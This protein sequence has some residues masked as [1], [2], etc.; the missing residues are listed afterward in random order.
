VF[1]PGPER[2]KRAS[3]QYIFFL[4]EQYLSIIIFEDKN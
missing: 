2:L 4:N 1:I 3:L